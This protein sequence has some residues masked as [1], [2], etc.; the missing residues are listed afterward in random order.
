MVIF[1]MTSFTLTLLNNCDRILPIFT[2]VTLIWFL[3]NISENLLMRSRSLSDSIDK[4]GLLKEVYK[5]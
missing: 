5:N 4:R 1:E 3:K 2:L